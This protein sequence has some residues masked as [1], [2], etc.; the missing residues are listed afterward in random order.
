MWLLPALGSLPRPWPPPVGRAIR[1]CSDLVRAGWISRQALVLMAG[2]PV[3]P[4][5]RVHAKARSREV[6]M[7]KDNFSP[8]HSDRVVGAVFLQRPSRAT[9]VVRQ[10]GPVAGQALGG[11]GGRSGLRAR[12]ACLRR[13]EF[14]GRWVLG[15]N[16]FGSL[17][18]LNDNY[19]N[20]LRTKP[21]RHEGTKDAQ[22]DS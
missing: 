11:A 1:G 18:L 8:E 3:G 4:R 21:Q 15:S 13:G 16:A 2:G 19:I 20:Q 7:R 5:S 10:A 14:S 9:A 6:P 17:L 22:R 12:R